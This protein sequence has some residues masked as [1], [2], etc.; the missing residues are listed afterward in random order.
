MKGERKRCPYCGKIMATKNIV[1]SEQL[2]RNR[3][4]RARRIMA[5]Y[6]L[7]QEGKTF[8]EIGKILGITPPAVRAR[9]F[10]ALR[11]IAARKRYESLLAKE[12][13]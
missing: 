3:A 12:A 1:D 13:P 7:R 10:K 8:V 11:R 6:D 2:K 5:A 9:Y 4:E